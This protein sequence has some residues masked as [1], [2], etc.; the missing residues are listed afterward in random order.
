MRILM[1]VRYPLVQGPVVKLMP[2][3]IGVLRDLGCQIQTSF[4]GRHKEHE[5]WLEK[6]IGRIQDL[7]RI[8]TELKNTRFE[9]VIIQTAHNWA[10]LLR[11]IP[12]LLTIRRLCPC[13]VLQM[14]GSQSNRM[15]APRNRLLKMAT[16]WLL[17]RCDAVLVLSTEEQRQWQ[18]FYP[19]GKFYV[20]DNPFLPSFEEFPNAQ[21]VPLE[22][23][24]DC[25]VLLFVGRLIVEKGVY[26]LLDS[27]PLVLRQKNCH[28]LVAGDGSEKVGFQKKVRDLGLA[29]SVT[30]L[31][32]MKGVQ[33]SS[34]YQ[35]ADIF[36]LPSYHYEGFPT[37]VT[38]AMSFGL[39]IITTQIRGIADH[40]YEGINALFVRPRDPVSLAETILKLLADPA[41]QVRMQNANREKVK[42]FSPA[43][44]GEKYHNV[45]KEIYDG[46]RHDC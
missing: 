25:S 14:H 6:F 16:K 3:L 15:V 9:V 5:T 4:W 24:S 31:G 22:I 18:Q 32:Y 44:V 2:L 10:T 43:I 23:P 38:E 41:L 33:L 46:H 19:Q 8:R 12:L 1:L 28:L 26:D 13:I 36:V 7:V 42:Q 29:D 40:L 34:I 27:M 17:Q 20:V 30:F 39:P 35:Q 11:E 45:L 21:S 37:V